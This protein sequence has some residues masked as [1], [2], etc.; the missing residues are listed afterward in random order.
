MTC[1]ASFAGLVRWLVVISVVP[2]VGMKSGFL[3]V[4]L[5]L[6]WQEFITL[7]YCCA[8]C[9]FYSNILSFSCWFAFRNILTQANTCPICAP[10]KILTQELRPARRAPPLLKQIAWWEKR[11]IKSR[12]LE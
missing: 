3:E 6:N 5:M 1:P 2:S 11:K 9:G 8:L 7:L 12:R 10:T 4:P